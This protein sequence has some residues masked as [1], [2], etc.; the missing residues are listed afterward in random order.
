[1]IVKKFFSPVIIVYLHGESREE[2]ELCAGVPGEPPP[3]QVA[4][5]KAAHQWLAFTKN[6]RHHLLR[7][8]SWR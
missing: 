3:C 4:G 6:T 2:P 8:T 5:R 7:W 1:M